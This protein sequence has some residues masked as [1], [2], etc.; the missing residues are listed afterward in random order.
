[1]SNHNTFEKLTIHFDSGPI[2]PPFCHR[3]TIIFTNKSGTYGASLNLEYYDRDEISEE[4]IFIEGFS[5]NDDH[6]WEGDLPEIWA[7]EIQKKINVSNW[8]KKPKNQAQLAIMELRIT[9]KGRSE[10]LYPAD[11]KVWEIFSQEIIQAI[12]ELSKKEAPL[13]IEFIHIGN[14][15]LKSQLNIK[16]WFSR[17]KV[18]I[19]S[20]NKV[21][22]HLSWQEGQKLMKYIYFFDYLPEEG[23][24]KFPKKPGDYIQPGNALWYN[25]NEME[26]VSKDNKT[27][28]LIA[29]LKSYF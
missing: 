23:K 15:H 11:Q 22:A 8:L 3:Y 1:M 4:D 12:F 18:E 9:S 27:D 21:K 25:L 2:P 17:R 29:T 5:L 19:S 20:S 13:K 16:F 7:K 28:K 10:L 24:E 26:T 14:N 6:K